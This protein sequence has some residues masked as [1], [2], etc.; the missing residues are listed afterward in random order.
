MNTSLKNRDDYYQLYDALDNAKEALLGGARSGTHFYLIFLID[1]LT[2]I[3]CSGREDAIKT[4]E[5]L[6]AQFDGS[7]E[8]ETDYYLEIADYY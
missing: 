5:R 7:T 3:R 2:G 6:L 4:G 1:K 8:E